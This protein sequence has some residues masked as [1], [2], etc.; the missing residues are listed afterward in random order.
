MILLEKRM[1]VE[2]LK[3]EP[4]TALL[5]LVN[6]LVFLAVEITGSSQ[7]TA[8]MLEWG[9]AYTPF[10]IEGKE[11][12]RLFTC[13]FLHFGISHLANNMLV[14]F[15]LGGKL[16]RAI[17][18]IKFLLIYLLGGLAG[19]ILSLFEELR[20]DEYAV[21]AGA[22]GAVFAVMGGMLYV[23]IRMKGRVEDI[24][25]KQITIM[26]AFSLYFGFT[27]AG[28]DNVA[29]IGGLLGGFVIAILLFHPKKS[30]ICFPDQDNF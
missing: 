4:M 1:T 9:A 10:I 24:S 25:V 21:S 2:E 12:Y 20:T 22:S 3:K 27:S 29:H 8:H 17:G 15:V 11:W 19:N 26:A 30:E 18:K 28:V 6:I 23:L 16:E 14:L 5:M 13:M 7:R